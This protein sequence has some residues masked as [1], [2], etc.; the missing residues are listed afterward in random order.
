MTLAEYIKQNEGCRLKVYDDSRGIPS[1]GW[2]RDLRDE[3]I[4]QA[5]AQLLFDN[6]LAN[7]IRGAIAALGSGDW[8]MLD[9]AR[10]NSLIDMCFE[11]GQAGLS[12]FRNMLNAVRKQDWQTAHDQLLASRYA[13]QV[14]NRAN[15][16][17]AILLTGIW[18]DGQT[19]G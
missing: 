19:V 13:E 15:R 11:L 6:D 10:K 18:P 16:N 2:G 3:G 8:T 17:A 7:A 5:E 9:D 14:P 1:I 4:S 12:E